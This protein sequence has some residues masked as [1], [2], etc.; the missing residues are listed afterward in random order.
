MSFD[1]VQM[2]ISS[3]AFR[4]ACA[5][6]LAF[7]AGAATSVGPCVAPRIVAVVALAGDSAGKTRWMRVTSFIGGIVSSSLAV[8]LSIALF[9]KLQQ[10][11][12]S[13]YWLTAFGLALFGVRTLWSSH[14]KSCS[15]VI[16]RQASAGGSYLLGASF[17]LVVSP[18][19]TPIFVALAAL[20]G[21]A[22]GPYTICVLVAFALGHAM[23]LAAAALGGSRAVTLLRQRRALGAAQ[24]VSG[25]LMV[26]LAAYYAVLA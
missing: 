14:G 4:T 20:R 18:C 1:V 15:H 6:A 3:A 23:P 16:S 2:A 17:G 5:P 8:A 25:A 12:A 7:A 21:I 24:V 11:T 9:L 22:T 13:M 19:C 26:A 10:A